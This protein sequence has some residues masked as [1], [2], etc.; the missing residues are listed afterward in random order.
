MSGKVFSFTQID[1][2]GD[3]SRSTSVIKITNA[4]PVGP[5]HS[6]LDG[7]LGNI[8][9]QIANGVN[10]DVDKWSFRKEEGGVIHLEPE[11]NGPAGLSMSTYS[12]TCQNS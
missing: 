6:L 10:K 9:Y 8:Y 5:S 2:P 3:H 4:I 11:L 12:V 1:I 7:F